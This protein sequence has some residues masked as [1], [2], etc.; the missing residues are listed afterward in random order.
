MVPIEQAHVAFSDMLEPHFRGTQPNVAEDN[1]QARIRGNVLMT[2][3]NKFGWMVLTTGNKSEMAMGYAT[4]YGDMAG[5][6]AV[7]KDVP[8]TP[9]YQLSQ[10]RH[11]HGEPHP[12]IPEA[13]INMAVRRR[14]VEGSFFTTC[15]TGKYQDGDIMTEYRH[16]FYDGPT[17][18]LAR[19]EGEHGGFTIMTADGY[20]VATVAVAD[21]YEDMDVA[22]ADA[23]RMALI[24]PGDSPG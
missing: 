10:W 22:V 12:V 21:D 14:G 24:R 3:S 20:P 15:P 18:V 23:R 7:L 2:I 5:V 16:E 9:V 13:I 4:L 1:V 17:D 19:G 8:K 11:H 6:F